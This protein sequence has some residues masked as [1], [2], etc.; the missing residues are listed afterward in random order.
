M[1]QDNNKLNEKF[2]L[3]LLSTTD[4][5]YYTKTQYDDYFY[6]YPKNLNL[7]VRIPV[8]H[9]NNVEVNFVK[10]NRNNNNQEKIVTLTLIEKESFLQE[11]YLKHEQMLNISHIGYSENIQKINELLQLPIDNS[12]LLI[13]G[14]DRNLTLM[15][16]YL[17]K[18]IIFNIGRA[19]E[20]EK[21]FNPLSPIV[22][23]C[24]ITEPNKDNIFIKKVI[25]T[26]QVEQFPKIKEFINLN[27]SCN[28]VFTL[29]E[30]INKINP[31]SSSLLNA[32]LLDLELS[33]S[34]LKTQKM[35]I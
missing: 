17:N 31:E 33:N 26:Y 27:P 6:F 11:L 18:K 7:I 16:P 30:E 4:S 28:E 2:T 22:I 12:E 14:T 29:I 32:T 24:F 15:S 3:Q 5:V 10:E 21:R 35:K 13:A 20:N 19:I 1:I 9:S 25:P 8:N 34:N 23:D